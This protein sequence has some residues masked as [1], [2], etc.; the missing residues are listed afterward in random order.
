MG[1][2]ATPDGGPDPRPARRLL[3]DPTFGPF[4]F[5]QLAATLAMWVQNIASAVLVFEITGSAFLVGLVSVAQFIPQ[6]VLA[7]YS[8]ALADRGSRRQQLLA[9]RIIVSSG[10]A[11]LVLLLLSGE[12][13]A[14]LVPAILVASLVS[15]IGYAVG[16]PAMFAITPSLVRPSELAAAVSMT[17]FPFSI[18]R[19]A[20]PA[21]GAV[22]L[23]AGGPTA[24]YL[25]A[26]LGNL[27]F[28][29]A[30]A[31]IRVRDEVRRTVTDGSVRAGLRFVRTEP[32]LTAALVGATAVGFGVDPVVTLTPAIADSLGSGAETVGALASVFGLGAGIGYP[33]LAP[34]RARLGMS[35]SGVLG[36]LLMAVGLLGTGIAGAPSVAILLMGV[37]GVGLTLAMTAYSTVIQA[38]A[39]DDLRGRVM[40]LYSI[41][42]IGMR[43]V[44]AAM[45]GAMADAFGV[46]A[47]L[48]ACSV[49]VVAGAV[50]AR[51]ARIET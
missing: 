20:G 14:S 15:G 35:G 11:G 27:A 49:V 50:I 43:P 7:P 40:S 34:L 18:G 44:S 22:L 4:F 48:A 12:D 10:V 46:G 28:A 37:A 29:M 25:F 30:L 24:A 47:A 21:V 3:V 36:L 5:G 6:V 33:L 8:G 16:G 23:G 32:R 45:T 51:P 42:F 26:V 41:A 38:L 31:R 1:S 9:G 17:A 39:P 13:S 2:P 19:T